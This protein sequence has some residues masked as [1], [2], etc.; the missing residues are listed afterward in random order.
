[1]FKGGFSDSISDNDVSNYKQGRFFNENKVTLCKPLNESENAQYTANVV[2]EFIAQAYEILNNHSINQERKR[3]GL[4]PAN[5][6]LLRNPGIEIPKLKFYRNWLSIVYMPLEIGFSR[7]SGMKPFT[8]QY[9]PLK[10]LDVYENLYEGLKMACNFS[11]KTIEK[12][13]KNFDYA[14][15][16]IKETDM[17]GH[18]NKPFEKKQMIEFIDQTLF[19]FLRKFAPPHE[20]KVCI[21][22]DHST[23]CY[24]KAHSDDPVP[25]LLYNNSIPKEKKFCEKNAIK[26][27]LGKIYGNDLLKVIGFN[28]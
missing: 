5:Y 15:I 24:L 14:Y 3:K 20:I 26:G 1:V 2:N 10:K 27:S 6:I 22:A 17:P 28:K 9:P 23:P 8:F 13:H 18:D 16:H 21:T 12:Q 25:L 4:M 19:K 7:L 11:I